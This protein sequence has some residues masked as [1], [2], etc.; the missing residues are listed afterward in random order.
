MSGSYRQCRDSYLS[1]L[2]VKEELE[3]IKGGVLKRV[4]FNKVFDIRLNRLLEG[5]KVI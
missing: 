4:F 3:I 2:R 5:L 1:I